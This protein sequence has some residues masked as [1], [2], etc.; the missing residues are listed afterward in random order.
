MKVNLWYRNKSQFNKN[1]W[2]T[3]IYFRENSA[4]VLKEK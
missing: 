1:I 2:E 4:D 3:E